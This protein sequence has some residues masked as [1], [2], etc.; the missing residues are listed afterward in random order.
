MLPGHAAAA[1]PPQV[2]V[3]KWAEEVVVVS[4]LPLAHWALEVHGA[5]AP[6]RGAGVVVVVVVVVVA[7][8]VVVVVV[9]VAVVVV[10]GIR[11]GDTV[12]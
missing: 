6:R 10:A 9:V 7:G 2:Q 3:F 1:E 8:L 11:V 5:S 4:H 12:V